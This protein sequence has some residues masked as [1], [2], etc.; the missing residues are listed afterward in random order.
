[1]R[2][3][4][5]L[6]TT[7]VVIFLSCSRNSVS[8]D[9]T[10]AKDEVPQ[11]GNLVFRFSKSLVKDSMLNRWDSTEFVSFEPK[12]PG[13]FRWES[14]SELVFSPSRPL[15]P[16]TS[17]KARIK[18][19]VLEHSQYGSIEKAGSLNFRT[20]DLKLENSNVTWVLPDPQSKTAVP[21]IDL[22]FNYA[23][24]P[25][26]LQD[27]LDIKVEGK[28]VDYKLITASDNA[29]VSLQVTSLAIQDKDYET[30]IKIDKGLVPEGGNNGTPED[31]ESRSGIPSPFVLLIN[32]VQSEHDGATGTIYVKTSQQ[33][34]TE[35]LNSFIK[36]NPNIRYT[37]EVTDDGFTISSDNF[38]VENSYEL[39]IAK[40]LRGVIGGV[41]REEHYNQVAFG[42][43]E[44]SLSFANSKAVYLS[45]QGARNIEMRIVNV[46]KVK[47]IMSKIYESNMMAAQRYGY[48]PQKTGRSSEDEYYYDESGSGDVTLGDVIY[49][50]E[51]ETR[52]LPKWGASRAVHFQYCRQPA[53]F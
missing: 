5:L 30:I 35:S 20:P 3:S 18:D 7:L 29:K 47:V 17:Y 10:N 33:V 48:Y 50:K 6:A 32:D 37:A 31:I 2:N 43:L 46:P 11:L 25:A 19:D 13:R 1:M 23:I 40:G 38:D 14:P 42:K 4:I 9:Y 36:F 26:S 44:P 21:Q 22:Y 28:D 52:F 45:A 16:A 12:I 24:K 41:L 8:L 49:E 27:K 34:L 15:Q 51:I 39:V 53:R